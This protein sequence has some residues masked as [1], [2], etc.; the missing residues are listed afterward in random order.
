MEVVSL[1]P[2]GF[3]LGVVK[4]IDLALKVAKENPDRKIGV[5]GMIVHNSYVVDT[6]KKHGIISYEYSF[7]NVFEVIDRIDADI[8]ILTAHGTRLDIVNRL[9]E[10][11]IEV[12][13][14]TCS[15]VFNT[16]KLIVDELKNNHEVVYIGIK[17]HPEAE[18]S[19]GANKERVHIISNEEDINSLSLSDESPLLVNQT[20]ISKRTIDHLTSLLKE[21]YPNLRFSNEQCDATRRRQDAVLNLPKDCD[22]VFIIGDKKSNNTKELYLLAKSIVCDSYLISSLK[23]LDLNVLKGKKKVALTSGASTPESLFKEVFEFL[24]QF[25]EVDLNTYNIKSFINHEIL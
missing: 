13:D 22:L 23:D 7:N 25:N 17:N 2:H 4:A 18:F 6:L 12:K 9:K 1:L 11:G 14:A 16:Y 19:K 21:K 24:K 5:L 10:R 3:C 20:T 8:V 15:Y